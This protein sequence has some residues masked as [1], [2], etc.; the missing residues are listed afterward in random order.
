MK[1]HPRLVACLF[2]SI[3]VGAVTAGAALTL[4][5]G[6]LAALMLYSLSGAASLVLFAALATSARPGI[7]AVTSACA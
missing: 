4:G 3:G 5:F 7:G 1:L 2:A 6:F